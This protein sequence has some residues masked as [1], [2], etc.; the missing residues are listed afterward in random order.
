MHELAGPQ[1]TMTASRRSLAGHLLEC[2][3]QV[4]GGIFTDWR[5]V[6]GWDDVGFPIAICRPDGSFDLTKP[7]GTGGLVT[8]QTVAEQLCYEVGDPTAYILPDVTCDWSTVSL[9][10][11]APM[12]FVSPAQRDARRPN[13]SRSAQ[14][15]PTAT[16]RRSP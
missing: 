10:Q 5:D 4:T 16:D 2:G 9:A 11:S 12:W 3:P 14:P 13:L 1:V 7:E 8:P 6:Q 15:I